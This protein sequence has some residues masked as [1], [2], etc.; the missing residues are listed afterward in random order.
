MV[1]RTKHRR[2]SRLGRLTV[3]C[4]AAVFLS[5]FGYHA[6]N[7]DLGLNARV[8]LEAKRAELSKT[9]DGLRHQRE[10]LEQR[11]S[12]LKGDTL[13]RDMLDIQSREMLDVTSPDDIVIFR[14]SN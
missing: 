3:P 8:Q 10:G 4:L 12:L 2:Q 13:D 5:Y 6:V 14:R 7:G 11:A 1:M 9:L